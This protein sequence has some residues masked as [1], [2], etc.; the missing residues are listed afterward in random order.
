MK[1]CGPQ[2]WLGAHPEDELWLETAT[3]VGHVE[4]WRVWDGV[5]WTWRVGA[6]GKTHP[7]GLLHP[8]G[9]SGLGSPKLPLLNAVAASRVGG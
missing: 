5:G 8:P 1:S 4:Y 6:G 3:K 9:Q 7:A 2:H